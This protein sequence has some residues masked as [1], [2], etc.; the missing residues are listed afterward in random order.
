[1]AA[2]NM[3]DKPGSE[4][5]PRV[6]AENLTQPSSFE[7]ICKRQVGAPWV[8]VCVCVCVRGQH[9]HLYRIHPNLTTTTPNPTVE[10]GSSRGK[11]S[12]SKM[13][14]PPIPRA[15]LSVCVPKK[16]RWQNWCC[17]TSG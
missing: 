15:S 9:V 8:Y 3:V 7:A 1:M 17:S 6:M 16:R 14:C 13:L 12:D 11:E 10:G 5:A 2:V 4:L